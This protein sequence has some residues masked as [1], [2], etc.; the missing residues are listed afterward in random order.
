MTISASPPRI[1]YTADGS[2]TVFPYPFPITAASDL[3]VLAL[4]VLKALNVDYT[5]SGV[6][7]ATGGNVTF[8][9]APPAGSL[10]IRRELVL[11]QQTD[12]RETGSFSAE[13]TERAFDRAMMVAQQLKEVDDR[14]LKLGEASTQTSKIID[15]LVAGK[16]LRVKADGS[17]IEMVD[18]ATITPGTVT[19]PIS[20]L[21]GGTGGTSALT[22]RQGLGLDGVVV[23]QLT[24]S[25]GAGV[26]AGDVLVVS[27]STAILGDTVSSKRKFVVALATI[28][29]GV[30]GDFADSGIGITVRVAGATT[31][32]NYLRKSATTLALEDTGTAA[33]TTNDPPAGTCAIAQ[34]GSGGAGTVTAILFDQTYPG[35]PTAV[36]PV[37][38]VLTNLRVFTDPDDPSERVRALVD[39]A[40]L[41]DSTGLPKV[42]AGVD[43]M[44]DLGSAG[45][46]GLDTGAKANS[47]GY[48]YYIIG[49][50]DGTVSAMWSKG[51]QWVI[52]QSYADSNRDAV[53]GLKDVSGRTQLAQ[54]FQVSQ[55]GKLHSIDVSL[56]RVGSPTGGLWAEIQ[57][58]SAGV[59]SG[60]L[61]TGGRGML[62]PVNDLDPTNRVRMR[63][64]FPQRPT[65]ASGTQYHLVL[66]G[67]WAVSGANYVN[68]GVDASAPAY[69]NGAMS[70][71]DG[72]SWTADATRDL[73]VFV[74]NLL[75]GTEAPYANLPAG[76][77]YAARATWNITNGSGAL[78][79]MEQDGAFWRHL[80]KRETTGVA[81]ADAWTF[82]DLSATCPAAWVE[83]VSILLG[84]DG[85]G[86]QCCIADP[87][88]LGPAVTSG[89]VS[90]PPWRQS[91]EAGSGTGRQAVDLPGSVGPALWL[92]SGTA[93]GMY[94]QRGFRL[95]L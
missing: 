7:V 62:L 14:S 27:G 73:A 78:M 67:E 85:N 57:T 63:L 33:N 48:D 53:L 90:S 59:P 4:G 84:V 13:T 58:N 37:G 76:Y 91:F 87:L 74:V 28:N 69:A 61:V 77:T 46:A 9:T 26:V 52:D 32:G 2:Q 21:N 1:N 89:T 95:A 5:V 81:A 49:K 50:P 71:F 38:T 24:N 29:S 34:T 6:G 17:G 39:R 83:T 20:V 86:I 25:S 10:V 18:A 80:E 70:A 19:V 42:F 72:A 92:A 56:L 51:L 64:V 82:A 66:K 3:R 23:K 16:L 94:Q 40:I 65:L 45:A 12:Y 30:A 54:G 75:T 8:T 68:V 88:P 36:L 35:T 79:R 43:V 44:A 15:D 55:A 93:T 31:A 60:T 41:V 22:G 11:E 47:T